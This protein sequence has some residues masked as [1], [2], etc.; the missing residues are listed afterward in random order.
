METSE[1]KA[2]MDAALDKYTALV[3]SPPTN[4]D[5]TWGGLAEAWSEYLNAKARYLSLQARDADNAYD[6]WPTRSE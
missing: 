4:P 5:R 3:D 2:K 1:A 6:A